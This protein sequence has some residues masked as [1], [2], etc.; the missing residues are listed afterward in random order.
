MEVVPY[1]F[2]LAFAVCKLLSKDYS[3]SDLNST[4]LWFWACSTLVNAIMDAIPIPP[5]YVWLEA[6]AFLQNDMG[7]EAIS[8]KF[9]KRALSVYPFSIMLWK[10]YYKLFL[11]IGDA[12]NILEEAKER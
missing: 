11:S 7:I 6:A 8:Q 4:S 12:N 1:N 2:Q 5:E 9:Y 3:S 10:C